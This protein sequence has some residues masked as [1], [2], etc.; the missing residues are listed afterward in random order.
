MP[1][2]DGTA[3]LTRLELTP[4]SIQTRVEGGI[5]D[6]ATIGYP[7]GKTYASSGTTTT[8]VQGEITF[9]M[10]G[11]SGGPEFQQKNHE[12]VQGLTLELHMKDGTV[13]APTI[14]QYHTQG[15]VKPDESVTPFLERCFSYR[16]SGYTPPRI[17][18]PS[19]VDHVTVCGVDI[20]VHPE[21]P[22]AQPEQAQA[23]QPEEAKTAAPLLGV[24]T[25]KRGLNIRSGPGT[26]FQVLSAAQRGTQLSILEEER[27][28]YKVSCPDGSVGYAAKKY[29][30]V[31]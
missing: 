25:P 28:F 15:P 1:F 3:V 14:E 11:I 5:C 24:V 16:E 4:M 10:G 30:A 23:G 7:E 9:G 21:A 13:F 22:A 18:D 17:I 20:P 12:L 31:L 8:L 2:L 27:D 29:I 26:S 6:P 19:Q